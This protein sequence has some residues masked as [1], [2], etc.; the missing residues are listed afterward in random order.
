[1]I[2]PLFTTIAIVM[3]FIFFYS[4]ISVKKTENTVDAFLEREKLSNSTRKQSID[5]LD[6]VTVD[7]AQLPTLENENNP[8]ILDLNKKLKEYETKK[9]VNLTGFTNTELKME[10]GVANLNI[11]S[12][13][14]LNFSD[15]TK[16]LDEL[17]NAY[18]DSSRKS[19][20]IKTLEYALSI[21]TDISGSYLLL[22][23]LY[24]ECGMQDKIAGVITSA[25]H[26]RSITRNSTIE[27]L[28]SISDGR[29]IKKSENDNDSSDSTD[30]RNILPADI[31]DILDN[32]NDNDPDQMQ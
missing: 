8:L 2:S 23:T 4:R 26:I 20:A 31:L 21:K 7:L 29:I 16:Y 19:E 30:G 18:N 14:D 27:K 1:M 3:I 32:L 12:E 13:Y 17:A 10:Y 15:F 25:E 5:D 6:Y 22:A 9:L 28:Y 24:A 11:L